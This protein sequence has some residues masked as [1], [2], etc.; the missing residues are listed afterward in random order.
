MSD[1]AFGSP[2][3]FGVKFAGVNAP[4]NWDWVDVGQGPG[5]AIVNAIEGIYPAGLQ[6][7]TVGEWLTTVP[8]KRVG[9]INGAWNNLLGQH[10]TATNSLDPN[11]ICAGSNPSS[12]PPGDPLLVTVPV[13][14]LSKVNGAG[15]FQVAGFAEVY[16]TG[17]TGAGTISGCF[18]QE[19]TTVPGST[20][21]GGP[22][23]GA[24]SPPTIFQ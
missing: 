13:G 10:N 20:G 12:I 9:Q 18:V 3:T 19:M 14:D 6:P 16:L 22:V 24:I 23:L 7:V 4:G 21:G 2:V 11:S 1:L 17:L 15:Q 5:G 8:G